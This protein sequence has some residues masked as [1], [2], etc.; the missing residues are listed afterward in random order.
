MESNKSPKVS[1]VIP[2]YR[3]LSM[4]IR[5]LNSIRMQSYTDYEVI[6]TDDTP[7]QE[8]EEYISSQQRSIVYRHNI[9]S[10]GSPKNWNFGLELCQGQYIKPMFTDDFFS[11]SDSL[12]KMVN[13]LDQNPTSDIAFCGS[14]QVSDNGRY[15]RAI[16][17]SQAKK[18]KK[19]FR[20]IY[21][22]NVIGAPS[23]VIFRKCSVRFNTDL[24]WL[25]DVDF[26]L[27][28]LGSNS[29]FAY[30]TDPL[31][32]IGIH[33]DQTTNRVASNPEINLREYSCVYKSNNLSS[34]VLCQSV[35][36]SRRMIFQDI[37]WKTLLK[38]K[39]LATVFMATIY[40]FIWHY[41]HK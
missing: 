38:E 3:N 11:E 32:S 27:R 23:A 28:I 6:I 8:V 1:I 18:L 30:T 41:Q 29:H 4:L 26:Y 17:H 16:T 20:Y 35:L 15:A 36:I 5:L 33:E 40:Y 34:S 14:W 7:G 31:V 25:V 37:T 13:L 9:P 19:D 10:L 39:S 22:A 12:Q 21:A 24:V 2:A